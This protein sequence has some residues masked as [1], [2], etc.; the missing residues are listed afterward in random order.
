MSIRSHKYLPKFPSQRKVVEDWA[1]TM[2]STQNSSR[3]ERVGKNW[4]TKFVQRH[5]ELS[6][7]YNR[8]IDYQRAECEVTKLISLWF[9]LVRDTVAKYGV[10]EEDIYSFDETGFQMGVISTSKVL[11]TSDRKGKTKDISAR[12]QRVGHIN[13]SHQCKGLVCPTVDHL[14]CKDSPGQV[15]SSWPSWNLEDCC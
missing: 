6:S 12:Q 2:L 4:A 14:C 7:I 11:T 3:P 8:K 1:N 13:G 15:V 9:K 10:A 5:L